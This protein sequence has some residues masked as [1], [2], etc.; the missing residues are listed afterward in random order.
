M[1][2]TQVASF[3]VPWQFVDAPKSPHTAAER[4]DPGQSVDEVQQIPDAQQTPV[5]Q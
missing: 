5:L 1:L 3:R 4:N 2:L